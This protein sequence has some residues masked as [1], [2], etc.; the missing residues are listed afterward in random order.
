MDRINP[1]KHDQ[2]IQKKPKSRNMLPNSIA[3]ENTPTGA[4]KTTLAPAGIGYY[5]QSH[6]LSHNNS[7][8]ALQTKQTPLFDGNRYIN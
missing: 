7:T 6:T 8:Q 3:K 1:I 5:Y 4:N 2:F